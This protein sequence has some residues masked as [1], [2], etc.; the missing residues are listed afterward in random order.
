MPRDGDVAADI[1][2]PTPQTSTYIP[3][4]ATILHIPALE[5]HIH[6]NRSI[7]AISIIAMITT[8]NMLINIINRKMLLFVTLSREN[9][10][11]DFDTIW[12]RDSFDKGK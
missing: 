3:I 4:T 8:C 9:L 11:S 5:N 2:P 1:T 7:R 12:Y 6:N 10:S